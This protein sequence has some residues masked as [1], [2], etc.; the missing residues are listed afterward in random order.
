MRALGVVLLLLPALARA[1]ATSDA[2][3]LLDRGV[4]LMQAG[5]LAAARDHFDK[6]RALVPDK[7]NPYRWLGLVDARLNRCAEAV[8]ELDTFLG[9]VPPSDARAIEAITVRDRCK[10]ELSPKVG[11]LVI[12]STPS[13][14]EVRLDDAAQPSGLTPFRDEHVAVGSHVVALHKDGF[15]PLTHVITVQRGATLELTLSLQPEPAAT[16]TA[17]APAPAPVVTARPVEHKRRSR[18][19]IAGVVVG[20]VAV[21]AIGVGLGVGLAASNESTYPAFRGTGL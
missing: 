12:D 13:G 19:W 8:Q 9:K 4:A 21:L 16:A 6:A 18:A 17:P 7:A 11:T 15:R 1:D 5:D 3:A 20:A 10:E 14:A 2:L